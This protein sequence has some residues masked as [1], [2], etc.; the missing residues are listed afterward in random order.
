[1]SHQFM[2]EKMQNHDAYIE[3]EVPHPGVVHDY[4]AVLTLIGLVVVLGA[5]GVQRTPS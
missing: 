2:L 1:L 4:L 5:A 3:S